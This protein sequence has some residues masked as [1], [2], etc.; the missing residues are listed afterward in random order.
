MTTEVIKNL[1]EN[2]IA[3]LTFGPSAAEDIEPVAN[4]HGLRAK[5]LMKAYH[6][7][8]HIAKLTAHSHYKYQADVRVDGLNLVVFCAHIPCPGSPTLYLL[9][10]R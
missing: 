8:S 6:A 3:G 2:D 1:G 7:I 9:S 10:S 5:G 4:I